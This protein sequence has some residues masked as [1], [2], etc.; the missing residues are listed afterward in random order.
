[1]RRVEKVEEVDE[2]LARVWA[3]EDERVSEREEE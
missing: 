2:E 1:M 3:G